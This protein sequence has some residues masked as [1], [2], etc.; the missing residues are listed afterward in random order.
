MS[1]CSTST[2]RAWTASPRPNSCRCSAPSAAII[3]MSVQG[4]PDYLR[5]AMLAGAREFLVKP[6]SAAT[7]SR[8]RSARST[9]A[10]ARSST[11][12]PRARPA[13][14]RPTATPS[15]CDAATGQVVT[16]FCAQGRRG[17]HDAG[18]QFRRGRAR[19]SSARESRSSTAA[20]SSATS[21]CCSTSTRRT[22]RSRTSRARWPVATSSTLETTLVDHS[23]GVRV[24]MAPPS[25]EMAE[26]ITPDHVTQDRQRAA[27]RRTTWSWSTARRCS[28]T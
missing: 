12:P 20:C 4:E 2:C 25:P 1:C 15:P 21:A 24:L 22:S 8:P 28:R 16:F 6:F 3:M 14:P 27:R 13:A 19:P 18:G 5:R 11:A 10:S 17:P 7:S 9:S 26:L 23:T